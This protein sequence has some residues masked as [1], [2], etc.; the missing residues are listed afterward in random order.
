MIYKPAKHKKKN[1][2]SFSV[3]EAFKYLNIKDL[4]SWQIKS[5]PWEPS[6]FFRER[7]KKLE[8]LFDLQ[9][10]EESKK[11]LIDAI[12]EEA[13]SD[14]IHLRIWKGAQL[15]DDETTGYVDYLIAERQRYL[16]KP[17]LCIVEAKK[18]DF[19]QGL[20]QCLVEMKAC[21]FNN[22]QVNRSI[23]VLGIVTNGEGWRFYQLKL[24]GT[25]LESGLYSTGNMAD[26][27]GRLHTLFL[28][29]DRSVLG[30][31]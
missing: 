18:D 25:V 2:S 7:L 13:L 12:C 14:C 3:I 23:D 22:N 8:D 16:D 1:F 4:Q 6:D 29:C 17:F 27:L 21:Q 20:A 19:E 15:S 11:L 31:I 9:S 10:Y 28:Q 24:D 26:L 5:T 30:F